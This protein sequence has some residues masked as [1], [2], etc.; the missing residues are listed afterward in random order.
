MIILKYK[1]GHKTKTQNSLVQPRDGYVTRPQ[2]SFLTSRLPL[3][4]VHKILVSLATVSLPGTHEAYS[5]HRAFAVTLHHTWNY[6]CP[7][8]LLVVSSSH[9]TQLNYHLRKPKITTYLT[10]LVLHSPYFPHSSYPFSFVCLYFCLCLTPPL[11]SKWHGRIGLCPGNR[12]VPNNQ[13]SNWHI[14]AP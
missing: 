11:K 12:Y 4:P 13:Q 9:R 10:L 3:L 2:P 8:L 5:L 1:Q 14:G 6:L 7:H